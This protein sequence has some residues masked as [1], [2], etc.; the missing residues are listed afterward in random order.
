MP[1]DKF[2][3]LGQHVALGASLIL[4]SARNLA[5]VSEI[6]SKMTY[7]EL[8][9]E[10]GYMNEYTGALFLPHTEIAIVSVRAASGD[11]PRDLR[12]RVQLVLPNA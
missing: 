9:T 8:N 12:R 1:R 6:A 3:Y 5:L 2:H 11:C 10:P 7:V 4:L